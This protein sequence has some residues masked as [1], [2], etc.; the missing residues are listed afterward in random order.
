MT[1]LRDIFTAFAPEYLERSPHLPTSH[2]KVISAIHLCQSGHYGHSLY[3]CQS[4][5]EK[6]RVNHS[7][8]NRHCPQCQ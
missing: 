8:G 5:G 4:C 1:T 2:R 3:Q 6:H 7:C